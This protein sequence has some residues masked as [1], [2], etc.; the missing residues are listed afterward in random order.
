M[1]PRINLTDRKLA[2]FRARAG[3][4][5]ELM[6]STSPG[7]GVRVSETGTRT[8]FLR[9]RFPGSAN[10]VRRALG[11]YPAMPLAEARTKAAEW[12]V[13]LKRGIDPR[14][15]E[16]RQRAKEDQKRKNT[17]AAVFEDFV[18]EKLP[19]ERHGRESERDIRRHLLPHWGARPITEIPDLDVIAVIKA[20]KVT[21]PMMARS[22][23]T[24]TRRLFAWAKEQRVYGLAASPC[25]DLKPGKLIGEKRPRARVF[26][27]DELFALW[28]AADRMGYP[29]GC[30]YKMLILTGL[31]L[32]EVADAMWKEIDLRDGTWTIPA[33]RMKG[34]PSKA[35]EHVVPLTDQI[36]QIL[37]SL[38][39][40]RAGDYLFSARFG[41]TPVWISDDVKN[42]VGR[43]MLRTL[44]AMA[45]R[46]GDDPARVDLPHW[47]NH[48]IRRSVRSRLSRLKI[49]EEAREAVLAHARPGIKGTYDLYDYLPEKHEALE[50]WAARLRDIV[51]PAPAN[52]VRL[53]TLRA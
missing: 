15:E 20:K 14:D 38:P 32:N 21:A 5:P 19:G 41:T 46:R 7:L 27:D 26:S 49:T 48:D 31:R 4:R 13:M 2:A 52:I 33:T 40:Y 36:L 30:I 3:E 43:R 25:I 1:Q 44:R 11:T 47:V 39:R 24:L 50:L 45:R 8:F 37:N 6:D 23:L 29:F 10:P 34:L 53:Q 18:A 16:Q 35:C 22:L 12:R 17:F 9:A 51:A 42:R 28:R